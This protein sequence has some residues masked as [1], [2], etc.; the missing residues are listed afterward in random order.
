MGL[1][2]FIK[3]QKGKYGWGCC[4]WVKGARDERGWD[5]KQYCM[6]GWK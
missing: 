1:N 2:D 6:G 4:I 5:A 3:S